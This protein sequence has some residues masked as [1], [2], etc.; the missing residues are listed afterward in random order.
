[1]RERG[2]QAATE[3]GAI[4]PEVQRVVDLAASAEPRER[5]A[6]A[7]ALGEAQRYQQ[8][9]VYQ[10]EELRLGVEALEQL[11]TDAAQ[12]VR[13]AHA[14][15]SHLLQQQLMADG[16]RVRW[17]HAGGV[18][19]EQR[20]PIETLAPNRH[21]GS[22]P[23]EPEAGAVH[24]VTLSALYHQLDLPPPQ[25]GTEQEAD[26]DVFAL[27]GYLSTIDPS[28]QPPTGGL[29]PGGSV[30]VDLEQIPVVWVVDFEREPA[31]AI[32]Y[33]EGGRPPHLFVIRGLPQDVGLSEAVT[34]EMRK[35]WAALPNG[36]WV[37]FTNS[38]RPQ[39]EVVSPATAMARLLEVVDATP[40]E[41]VRVRPDDDPTV[42]FMVAVRKAGE[43]G[44]G[45]QAPPPGGESGAVSSASY[46]TVSVRE[47]DV[48][49]IGSSRTELVG[50][51]I[52]KFGEA[53]ATL[54]GFKIRETLSELSREQ[55]DAYLEPFA[56][57]GEMP[58][59]AVFFEQSRIQ[60]VR[61][62][63]AQAQGR[64]VL[65]GLAGV[66]FAQLSDFVPPALLALAVSVVVLGVIVAI[67]RNLPRRVGAPQSP[68]P[69][70]E[71]PRLPLRPLR[72][73]RPRMLIP[74]VVALSALLGSALDLE[75]NAHGDRNGPQ[76]PQTNAGRAAKQS[77]RVPAANSWSFQAQWLKKKW[78]RSPLQRKPEV[79]G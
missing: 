70:E 15:A 56:P 76:T 51:D 29:G 54:L 21:L 13:Y 30:Y 32:W 55:V 4:R 1:M 41:V 49:R 36:K 72:D 10:F 62:A 34:E 57:L 53:L 66:L 19:I 33:W 22:E 38:R 8:E 64:G 52:L 43:K 71:P 7:A 2:G 68:P 79:C 65:V 73:R 23:R 63:V 5:V 47:D 69:S 78:A 40:A 16:L 46:R 11:R 25:P 24:H 12:E 60:A 26:L 37:A 31:R 44:V 48:L 14:R 17:T 59:A 42:D 75:V 18:V 74:I 61:A 20:R 9:G 77:A 39:R 28:L 3:L 50:L 58:G 35:A 27:Q 67:F 6:A 45:V